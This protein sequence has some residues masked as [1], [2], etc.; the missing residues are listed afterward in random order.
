M[1]EIPGKEMPAANFGDGRGNLYKPD[2]E[3]A[4]LVSFDARAFEKKTNEGSDFK[5]V[6]ALFAA[7]SG[8]RLDPAAWRARLDQAFDT[9]GFL[10]WLAVNTTMT[11]WDTYGMLAHNFYLYGNPRNAGRLSWIPWDH[12]ES[13][14][15]GFWPFVY[16]PSPELR[17]IGPQWPLIRTLLDDPTYRAAYYRHMRAFLAGP[18]ARD[19]V[20]A[21]LRAEHALVAPFVVGSQGER[22]GFT[23][24][25]K[26][27]D[28]TDELPKLV[29]HVTRRHDQA[30]R[31]ARANP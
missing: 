27:Q 3:G 16:A 23:F 28:F 10:R 18:F 15:P 2:G 31:A 19:A 4:K 20:L 6:E 9:D 26:P 21:R 5:D 1:V 13:F 14:K 22:P 17:E 24:L 7:V 25:A 12:N 11:N 29:D 30:V 8:P